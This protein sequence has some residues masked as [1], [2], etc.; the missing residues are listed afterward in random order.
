M[1]ISVLEAKCRTFLESLVDTD[2]AHDLVHTERVVSNARL[3]L[4]NEKADELITIAAAWLHDC[5]VLPKNDPHR[6]RA[7]AMAAKKAVNFLREIGYPEIKL[8]AVGHAI[9][10][11][12][13]SAGIEPETNEAKIVQDADRLDALGAIG[14][15]RCMIVGGKLDRA[16]YDAGDPFCSS[17]TP[18][19]SRFT[20][21]HFYSKL[22]NLPETM[23]TEAGKTEAAKRVRFMKKYLDELR[24][25]IS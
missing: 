6:N 8:P 16:L 18:D 10:A 1:E 5:V 14:I 13:F 3:I 2:A 11:H 19:D 7:S 23:N 20:I 17:R 25:E 4:K 22:F 15:A 21:D 12:S 24:R 9:K